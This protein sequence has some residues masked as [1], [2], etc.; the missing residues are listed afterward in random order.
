MK[1]TFEWKEE[2]F[3]IGKYSI[4]QENIKD[5]SLCLY[6]NFKLYIL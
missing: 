6:H 5:L 3:Y 1:D 2:I 4:L